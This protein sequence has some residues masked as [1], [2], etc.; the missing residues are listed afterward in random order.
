MM[1]LEERVRQTLS[2]LGIPASFMTEGRRPLHGESED[3]VSIGL[4]MFGREQRLERRAAAQGQ[5]MMAAAKVEGVV[6][7]AISGF[8]SFDY[9]R[10]IIERK[11]AAGLT[12][13][14]ILCVSALPG[15]SE[16]HTGRAMDVGTPGCPPVTEEFERTPAFAWLTRHG[17]DF[18][19]CMTYPR[20]NEFGIVYEPCIGCADNRRH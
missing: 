3:L 18:G 2:E 11:L 19:F 4:D 7:L 15:F 6:L 12:V 14:Q 1:S 17:A 10:K 9:Q 16:H 13:E 5:K 8:R 20:G